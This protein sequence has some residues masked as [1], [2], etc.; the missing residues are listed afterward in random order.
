[1]EMLVA[2]AIFS[3][4]AI[5]VTTVALSVIK[6]QRRAF[7]IQNVQETG[8]FI[9]ESVSKEIRTS[10]VESGAGVLSSLDIINDK[11]VPV[12]YEFDGI[13]IKRNS[14]D[15]NPDKVDVRG[16]FIVNERLAPEGWLVTLVM[17][18]SS[19]GDRVEEQVTIDLQSSVAPR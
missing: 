8:R 11:N 19:A 14:Q 2:M 7:A 4:L 12:R 3:G 18:L 16:A 1:M 9:L 17:R 6:S 15:L 13:K 10:S 5:A